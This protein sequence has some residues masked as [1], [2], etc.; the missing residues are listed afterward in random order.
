M[1]KPIAFVLVIVRLGL[2]ACTGLGV[3]ASWAF[4]LSSGIEIQ[5]QVQRDGKPGVATE[6]WSHYSD[7]KERH[8]ELGRAVAV[9][10][11]DDEGWPTIIMDGEATF[12]DP[13]GHKTTLTKYQG[14]LLQR[15]AFYKFTSSTEKPL[16]LLRVSATAVQPRVVDSRKWWPGEVD[17]RVD[18]AERRRLDVRVRVPRLRPAARRQQP[19]A[20]D[21]ALVVA[22]RLGGLG[23][24][25]HAPNRRS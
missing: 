8:P 4:T 15:G 23:G 1:I 6:I 14:I 5:C 9:M 11:L 21:A 10:R 18:A 17:D 25:R 16:V 2:L 3:H 20:A 24:E 22:L 19:D 12:Q 13:D 7:P